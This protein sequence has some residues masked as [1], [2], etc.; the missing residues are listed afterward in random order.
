MEAHHDE[1]SD[2]LL[3]LARLTA[4]RAVDANDCWVWTGAKTSKGY[5]VLWLEGRPEYVHR[6][7]AHLF[8]GLDRQGDLKALHRCDNPPCFNPDHLFLGTQTD[9][10]EDATRKGRMGKRLRVE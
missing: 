5:G 3:L 9:N 7:S 10:M 8:I 6:L 1:L 2:D 4:K